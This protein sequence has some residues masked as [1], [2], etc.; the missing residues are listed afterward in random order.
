MVS[1]VYRAVP[2]A[3]RSARHA[4][5][6]RHG[7]LAIAL[8]VATVAG[9]AGVTS[10]AAA[11]PAPTATV[12][13]PPAT[14]PGAEGLVVTHLTV[15]GRSNPVGIG[16]GAPSL[17]WQITSGQPGTL[18]TAYEVEVGAPSARG[19]AE[20]QV[21]SP[22]RLGPV[23]WNSGRVV[24]SNSIDVTYGG[25]ALRPSTVYVWRVRIWD[26]H[27]HVSPW[28]SPAWWET[29]LFTQADWSGAQWIGGQPPPGPPAWPS[30]TTATASSYHSP[31][32]G[33]TYAPQ[34][35][36]DGNTATYWN[37][38]VAGRFPVWL[39]I[40]SP[41]AVTLP[42]VSILSASDGYITTFSVDTWNGSTWVRQAYVSGATSVLTE[43]H[44][45]APVTTTGI[46]ITVDA[47]QNT[48]SGDYAR[49]NE[50]YAGLYNALSPL[51]PPAPELRTDFTLGHVPVASAW[52]YV[53]AGG[54]E[55]SYLNGTRV[56]DHVL[57]PGFTVYNKRIQYVTY[58]VTKLLHG[59]QNALGAVLGNGFY[60]LTAPDP[61][62]W[63]DS[64]WTGQPRLL[65]KLVVTYANGSRQVVV[66]NGAWRAHASPTQSDSVYLGETYDA[67]DRT[68]GWDTAGYDAS[69]WAPATV[70]PAPTTNVVPETQPPITV[71][72]VL[73]ATSIT[74][75]ASGV[76]VYKFPYV[77]SGW[78]QLQV[79]GQAG[80]SVHL[81]YGNALTANGTVSGPNYNGVPGGIDTYIL[82]GKGVETW[83]PRFSY[84]SFQYVQVTGY[85]GTPTLASV[86]AVVLHS[87]V[88]TVGAFSSSNPLLNEIYA[89]QKRT[90]LNNLYGIPTAS[91]TWGKNG[92]LG[93]AQLAAPG[94]MDSFGM[95]TFYANWLRD[96][97]DS[98]APSGQ[99]PV[100]A[101]DNGWGLLSSAPEWSA[102][103]PIIAWDSYLTYGDGSVLSKDYPAMVAYLSYLTRTTPSLIFNTSF[104][105]WL[106]PVF[107]PPSPRPLS[108]NE[109]SATA[110][111]DLDAQLMA[112]IAAALGHAGAARS[113]ADLAQRID[114]VINA[115]FLDPAT[116]SY[117]GATLGTWSISNGV[118]DAT[119]GGTGL[120]AGGSAW[121]NYTMS[122]QTAIQSDQSGWAVRAQ[123]PGNKYLLILDA[124]N[125]AAGPPNTLQE[126]VQHG[127]TYTSVGQVPL[128][129]AVTPGTSYQVKIVAAGPTVTTW[130]DGS[131][132]ASF[133]AS[134]FP[135]GVSGF[136]SG[137][138]GF[139]ENT[140]SATVVEQASYADLSV[141]AAD[142]TVLYENPLSSAAALADFSEPGAITTLQT[143]DAL[144][145]AFGLT[146][147][148]VIAATVANLVAN[149]H[150]AGDHLNT[151]ILGTAALLPTLTT[152]GHVNL[153]YD[154]ATQT[155][156]PGWGYWVEEG[157]TTNPGDGWLPAPGDH[158][159][160]S[161][162]VNWLYRD[163]AG[164]A[165]RSP[166][167]G[168]FVVKPYVPAGL[169][170]ARASIDTVRG[171]VAVGWSRPSSGTLHL[172][173]TVP[174]N[175]TAKVEVPATKG[176]AVSVD[177]APGPVAGGVRSVGR[178]ATRA[179]FDVG[180]GTVGFTV[181]ANPS[182]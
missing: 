140:D 53:S 17:G 163:L 165:S 35:A 181:T 74:N 46:R 108:G 57:D 66:S 96:I 90:I 95:E 8:S 12:A 93:D 78:A 56:G 41:T 13:S 167:Y 48:P 176:A 178:T 2:G 14:P 150:A 27:A 128:P 110:Y 84:N 29:G 33:Q 54:Y 145:L 92:W 21:G 76:Y 171:T 168:T 136:S 94:A 18:Q 147:P 127:G 135:A 9:L 107:F 85:P 151:G 40:T 169:D 121:T 161:S 119:G 133:D 65:A 39:A 141:I 59:G 1:S 37:S 25:P 99:L 55:V 86:Q 61:W 123:G 47:A 67:L 22:R 63:N 160:L 137:T 152:S 115:N 158:D 91:P 79:E 182:R 72:A 174:V 97:V 88:P 60:N 177:T 28:S 180:S 122:F 102:A 20:G 24:S 51:Q 10:S 71:H 101:P 75:P 23:I 36:I 19:V 68:P 156:Y 142:G 125:D 124:S 146:P 44:F 11:A 120:L 43:V 111:V 30:G 38:A 83:Q 100:I 175:S 62:N 170:G 80:T 104:G 159:M 77:L 49:I 6:L 32:C 69:S 144:A 166:G 98:Q 112:K 149:V 143:P 134:D 87:N 179:I 58:D 70:V 31:C 157:F 82:D 164:I 103:L 64:P 117:H 130:I 7:A 131:Q 139:R 155:T 162:V 42:G 113:Y 129:F 153:A 16:G 105:D 116:G 148:G 138:V 5:S 126:L 154:V 132:V 118:L 73:T 45:P 106:S 109:L 81:Q 15:G 52:L 4:R 34:N 89:M 172:T 26:N 50:V 114:R 3:L 173:V